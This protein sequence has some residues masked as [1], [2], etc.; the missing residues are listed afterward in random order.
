MNYYD[1]ITVV[2]NRLKPLDSRNL[3]ILA[4]VRIDSQHSGLGAAK[5]SK[6]HAEGDHTDETN[7]ADA[8]P[9]WITSKVI[10]DGLNEWGY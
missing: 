10:S 3:V 9:L 8:D 1:V 4:L 7:Y 5:S 6:R 2:I